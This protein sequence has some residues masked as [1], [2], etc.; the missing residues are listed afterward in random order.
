MMYHG[1][2]G[3][4]TRL[5]SCSYEKGQLLIRTPPFHDALHRVGTREPCYFVITTPPFHDAS[6]RVGTREP[7]CSTITTPP[8][9]DALHRVGARE[10]CC[11]TIKRLRI[12]TPQP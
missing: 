5:L 9:Y 11:F 12:F 1:M 8:F 10:P 6:H 3:E 2:V 4:M 7:C